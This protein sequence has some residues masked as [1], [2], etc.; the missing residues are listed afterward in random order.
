MKN[1]IE[2][3]ESKITLGDFNWTMNKMGSD[4]RNKT[5]RLYRCHTNY[6]LS[7]LVVNNGSMEK[8]EPRF[9]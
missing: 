6:A 3:N 8:G 1:K 7:Q 9:F 2:G 4:G 5:Q